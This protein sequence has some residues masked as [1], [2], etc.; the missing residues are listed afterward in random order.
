M[1][2]NMFSPFSPPPP[3]NETQEELEAKYSE[4]VYIYILLNNCFII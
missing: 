3:T 2:G 1:F 4:Y